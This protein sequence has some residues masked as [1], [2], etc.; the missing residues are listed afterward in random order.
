LPTSKKEGGVLVVV[1]GEPKPDDKLK[2]TKL[3]LTVDWQDIAR[4]KQA[5]PPKEDPQ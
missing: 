1:N 3:P 4:K 5:E 2:K